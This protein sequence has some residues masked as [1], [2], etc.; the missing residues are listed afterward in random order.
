MK[1]VL[2]VRLTVRVD[3]GYDYNGYDDDGYDDDGHEDVHDI[4]DGDDDDVSIMIQ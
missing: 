3:D 2:K 1:N 4:G